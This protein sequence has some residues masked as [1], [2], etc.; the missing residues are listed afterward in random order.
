[1]GVKGVEARQFRRRL[2]G[3]PFMG[4][5][6]VHCSECRFAASGKVQTCLDEGGHRAVIRHCHAHEASTLC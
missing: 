1:V 6:I 2:L 5:R 4:R 3:W